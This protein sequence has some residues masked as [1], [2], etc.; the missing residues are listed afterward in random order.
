MFSLL[1]MWIPHLES[2]FLYS[3]SLYLIQSDM[4]FSHVFWLR[5]MV[6]FCYGKYIPCLLYC[7]SIHMCMFSYLK[8]NPPFLQV[9]NALHCSVLKIIIFISII[10]GFKHH[11][12]LIGTYFP[13][14]YFIS[15][16]ICWFSVTSLSFLCLICT[17][18][19]W[20]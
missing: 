12:N 19:K 17:V 8:N 11:C 14:H 20:N 16:R 6:Y 13:C 9:N 3:F 7:C 5:S 2:F 18:F 10:I 4:Y 1:H 15:P